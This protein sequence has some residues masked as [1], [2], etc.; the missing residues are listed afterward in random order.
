MKCSCALPAGFLRQ[1]RCEGAPCAKVTL[2][3]ARAVV[4]LLQSCALGRVCSGT[5]KGRQQL[6]AATAP[7]AWGTG[8][9]APKVLFTKTLA[10]PGVAVKGHK[11][12]KFD[13][14][15]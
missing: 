6:R 9:M 15:K 4:A 8:K 12:F 5:A 13:Y 10:C 7:C 11:Y 3:S 14:S 2:G 1:A